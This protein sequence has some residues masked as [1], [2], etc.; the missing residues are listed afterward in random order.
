MYNVLQSRL[1]CS[2]FCLVWIFLLRPGFLH[3]VLPSVLTTDGITTEQAEVQ[4]E[5]LPKEELES[6]FREVRTESYYILLPVQSHG[7]NET[8]YQIT[9]KCRCLMERNYL[10]ILTIGQAASFQYC[11]GDTAASELPGV[12]F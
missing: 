7:L 6:R 11:K 9:F 3:Q 2:H 5:S 1:L 12:D 8:S 4:P 10:F